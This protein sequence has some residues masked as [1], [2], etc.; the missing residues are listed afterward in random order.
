MASRLGLLSSLPEEDFSCPVC[1]D[2]YRDPVLLSC[3]H[4]FCKPCLQQYW[5]H[6]EYLECPIC[7]RRLSASGSRL[8]RNLVL[9]NL[10]EAF[11][12]ERELRSAAAGW[13]LEGYCATHGERLKLYCLVDKQPLC[14]VCQ[15]SRLHKQHACCSLE[16]AREDLEVSYYF[17]VERK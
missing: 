16:E 8:V 2:I 6:R 1:C 4:S 17:K 15:I 10:C 14:V 3:S 7:R 12:K 9:K 5:E 11:V 13:D